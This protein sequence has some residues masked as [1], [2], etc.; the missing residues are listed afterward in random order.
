MPGHE[1]VHE[2]LFAVNEEIN[3][4]KGTAKDIQT[5][6]FWYVYGNDNYAHVN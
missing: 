1:A 4:L 3:K 5:V 2:Y 6:E